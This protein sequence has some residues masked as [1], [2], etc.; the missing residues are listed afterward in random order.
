MIETGCW[1][2]DPWW[3]ADSW[4]SGEGLSKID[5]L[6]G[7]E[8]LKSL[9]TPNWVRSLGDDP[10][11]H[12]FLQLVHFGQ[13][14]WQISGLY[15]LAER[16]R[17]L[18]DM[19]GFTPV[20]K[21]YKSLAEARSADLE[22]FMAYVM[23]KKCQD[24]SFIRAKSKHGRT[25]D[26]LAVNHD[27]EFVVECKTVSDSEAEIWVNNYGRSYSQLIMDAV[28]EGFEVIFWSSDPDVNPDQY[29]YLSPRSYQ[30]AAAIDAYPIIR[31]IERFGD[32]PRYIDMGYPG[33]LW[34]I[35]TGSELRSSIS[36]PSISKEFVG[37]RLVGNA[38]R[39]AN[40]QISDYGKPGIAAISYAAPPDTGALLTKLPQLFGQFREEYRYLMG[41]LILPAPNI[42]TYI[43]PVW[44]ANPYSDFAPAEVG[45]PDLLL[46]ALDPIVP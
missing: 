18:R 27:S 11:R 28:P 34:I 13:G 12:P 35:P 29:N 39:K 38:I 1:W 43:R 24:V 30:L 45:L 40:R 2:F 46:E 7:I 21:S 25:P 33:Q 20:L 9:L 5:F 19:E 32:R 44:V 26:I 14:L 22:T 31:Q 36:V 4:F 8:L 15:A 23:A 41:V 16:F 17:R 42:L 6:E 3:E 10:L 37:R